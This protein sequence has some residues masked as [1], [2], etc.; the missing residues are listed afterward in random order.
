MVCVASSR[1]SI[2]HSH[3]TIQVLL[4]YSSESSPRF[5][6]LIRCLPDNYTLKP[7]SSKYYVHSLLSAIDKDHSKVRRAG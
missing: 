7:R 5:L 4:C 6:E 3:H 1:G 2:P